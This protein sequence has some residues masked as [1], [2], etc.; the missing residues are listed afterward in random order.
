MLCVF[1]QLSSA[2]GSQEVMRNA[3]GRTLPAFLTGG[4]ISLYDL[5][6]QHGQVYKQDGKPA[7]LLTIFKKAGCNCMRVRIWVHP[8][9][10]GIFVNNLPYTIKLGR[11]IKKAGLKLLLDLHYSDTWADGGHQPTPAAWQGLGI[12][13]LKTKLYNYTRKV[14]TAMR[15]GGAMPDIVQVGN[16]ITG[17]MCWPVGKDFGPGNSFTN[18]GILLKAGIKGV[19]DGSGNLPSPFIMIHID[20]GGSWQGTKWFFDNII[21]QGVKFDIIGESYYPIWQGSLADLR[22]TLNHAAETFHKPIMVVETGYAYADDGRPAVK[23]INY[24]KTPAGQAQFLSDVLK[25][26][27]D[28]PDGLGCGVIY[29]APEWIPMKGVDGSWYHMTLFDGKGN[30]LPGLAVLGHGPKPLEMVTH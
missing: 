1:P 19:K 20:R 4:D 16:E 24:P 17:G 27:R 5:E 13:Q 18:L 2:F 15:R 22:N 21:K 11:E 3:S 25:I 9:D 7:N 8:T 10:Q 26:V 12:Q 14:I 30:V 28:T 6:M 23:G 29:W